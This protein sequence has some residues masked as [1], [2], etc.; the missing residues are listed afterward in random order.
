M[1][2]TWGPAPTPWE[3]HTWAQGAAS[4]PPC[5]PQNSVSQKLFG[6]TER[7]FGSTEGMRG[8]FLYSVPKTRNKYI[9]HSLG[10]VVAVD[11]GDKWHHMFLGALWGHFS[12]LCKAHERLSQGL[13]CQTT[14]RPAGHQCFLVPSGRHQQSMPRRGTAQGLCR[15][16]EAKNT[17]CSSRGACYLTDTQRHMKI[18]LLNLKVLDHVSM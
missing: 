9:C 4:P 6:V 1:S 14:D 7:L 18:I 2:R 17:C 15:A 10:W 16:R 13:Y 11:F 3:S 5:L 8:T 12:T